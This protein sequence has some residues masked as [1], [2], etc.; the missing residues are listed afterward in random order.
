MVSRVVKIQRIGRG[1]LGRLRALRRF[2]AFRENCANRIKG[3]YFVWQAKKLLRIYRA[4]HAQKCALKLQCM[5]RIRLARLRVKAARFRFHN[6]MALKIG[7]VAR[8]HLG[9]R[10]FSGIKSRSRQVFQDLTAAIM[11]DL[12]LVRQGKRITLESIDNAAFASEW[13]LLEC[14]LLNLLGTNRR[15]FA[16]DIATELVQRYP[17]FTIGRFVLQCA[18][19]LTWTCSG[20]TEHVKEDY[21]EEFVGI[22]YHNKKQTQAHGGETPVDAYSRALP[23][24]QQADKTACFDKTMDEIEYMYFRNA[25]LRH[26]KS[27]AALASM[28]A[29]ALMR[30]PPEN[31]A[32][33]G[34]GEGKEEDEENSGVTLAERRR[35]VQLARVRRLL[36]QSRIVNSAAPAEGNSRLKVFDCLFSARHR[37]IRRQENTVFTKCRMLGLEGFS[38]LHRQT[39]L[40]LKDSLVLNV[41]VVQA[42]GMI[43]LRDGGGGGRDPL[44]LSMKDLGLL[45][46]RNH[47]VQ[48][49]V[50][51]APKWIIEYEDYMTKRLEEYHVRPLVITPRDAER[52]ANLAMAWYAKANKLSE[53]EARQEGMTQILSAYLLN[54]VRLV[55]ARSR[56]VCSRDQHE[57]CSLRLVIPA[58]DYIRRDRN[59]LQTTDYSIKMM[60]RVFRGYRGKSRFRRLYARA[61]EVSRQRELVTKKRL[62]LEALRETRIKMASKIQAKVRRFLWRRLMKKLHRAARYIQCCARCRIARKKV[63]ERRR[64]R[65]MGPEVVEMLRRA[66]TVGK[67]SFTLI[68]YRCGDNYRMAGHDMV[69]NAIYEGSLHRPE[70]IR[71]IEDHNSKINGLGLVASKQRVYL[72][73]YYSVAE[74][75]I[76][77]LGVATAMSAVTTTLG[78]VAPGAKK[79]C[80]VVVPTASPSGNNIEKVKNLGRILKDQAHI[81][82]RYNK[83][84]EA[85]QKQLDGTAQISK[86][87]QYFNLK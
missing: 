34:D 45:R 70:V 42:G 69:N 8:G 52:L 41:E 74:L 54:E 5:Y 20:N 10:R 67:L 61:K 49:E 18:L 30:L 36:E 48:A 47:D 87:A 55:T 22:L 80:L 78:A 81:V 31:F 51:L 17:D 66:V 73:N 38:Q 25:F 6:L 19:F 35:R 68:M 84:L 60:Q 9:R 28:A 37:V 11:R 50:E 23:R 59:N 16:L 56:L 85:K 13:G 75:I 76:S 65:D 43:I 3:F 79:L 83:L 39:Q 15:D 12:A 72:Q 77:R 82:E 46:S 40:N 57:L 53:E 27:S 64:R 44:P 58:L 21:L 86:S 26:G 32:V 33:E 14:A 63:A 7:R 4:E 29:C 71:L 1:R 2:Q 62:A 24:E